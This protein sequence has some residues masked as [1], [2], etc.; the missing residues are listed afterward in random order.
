MENTVPR[1]IRTR[2]ISYLKCQ[3]AYSRLWS[4][5]SPTGNSCKQYYIYIAAMYSIF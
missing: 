3:D 1:A 4:R 5:N 2:N